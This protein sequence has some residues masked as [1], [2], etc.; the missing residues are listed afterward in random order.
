MA[1]RLKLSSTL[2]NGQ[3]NKWM[4]ASRNRMTNA[5]N[6]CMSNL[7]NSIIH[8]LCRTYVMCIFGRIFLLLRIDKQTDK[9]KKKEKKKFFSCFF[10]VLFYIRFFFVY[11]PNKSFD[12]CSSFNR[13]SETYLA[14][15]SCFLRSNIARSI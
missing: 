5:N 11:F 1:W 4:H 15:N 12:S 14:N 13:S 2:V 3:I 8:W 10:L 6:Q 9:W 7:K